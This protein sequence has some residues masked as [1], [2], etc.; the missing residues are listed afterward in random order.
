[1]PFGT[2]IPGDRI[3]DFSV[4]GN[5]SQSYLAMDKNLNR[6]VAVKDLRN[7]RIDGDAFDSFIAEIRHL[8]ST[9]S[10]RIVKVLYAGTE[11]DNEGHQIYRIVTEYYPNGTLQDTIDNARSNSL[12]LNFNKIIEIL[13]YTCNAVENLHKAGVIHNDI[14]PSNILLDNAL[15]PVLTDF[16]QAAIISEPFVNAP[17]TYYKNMSPECITH[18]VASTATDIYQIGLLIHR[19]V[20]NEK[21]DNDASSLLHSDRTG[22]LLFNA[23]TNGTFPK[24]DELSIFAPAKL[25]EIADKCLTNNPLER[26]ESIYDLRKALETV[27]AQEVTF[28]YVSNRITGT[29][30]GKQ[31]E[32]AIDSANDRYKINTTKSGR[33]C[34]DHCQ[35]GMTKLQARRFIGNTLAAV[36]RR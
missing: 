4:Q 27:D 32:L 28:N 6:H 33:K 5:F 14:K 10:N 15:K 30:N 22:Q 7:D 16:G 36:A 29:L 1:M 25:C 9:K 26:Y 20:D 12:S 23:I 35:D 8:T 19:L 13:L 2:Y 3:R 31:I 17:K 18:G 24:R 34:N 21:F 11:T